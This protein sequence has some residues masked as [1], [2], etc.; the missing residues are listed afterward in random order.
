L[1][2]VECYDPALDIWT[3]IA[4]LSERRDGVSVG[5][6]D[7]FM[8]AIGGNNKSKFLKSV[9]VYKP[10]DGVWSFIADMNLCRY[11]PGN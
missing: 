6:L 3:P 2:S 8:Y 1:K 11:N 4:E 9:E 5:V 7:G 10:S